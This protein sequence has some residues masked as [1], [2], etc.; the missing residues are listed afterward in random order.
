MHHDY[1]RLENGNHLYI[2]W[3]KLPASLNGKGRCGFKDPKDPE[4]MWADV[5]QEIESD[6]T[7]VREWRSG[8]T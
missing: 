4:V 7:L 1:V 3:D 8:N 5:I 6:G 2:A